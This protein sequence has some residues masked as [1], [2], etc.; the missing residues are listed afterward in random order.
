MLLKFVAEETPKIEADSVLVSS[1]LLLALLKLLGLVQF[2]IEDPFGIEVVTA[3]DEV[4]LVV[5][6]TE[7]EVFSS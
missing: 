7:L 6:L 4:S 3:E 1:I 5:Q 2:P